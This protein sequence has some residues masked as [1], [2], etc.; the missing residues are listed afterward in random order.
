MEDFITPFQSAPAIWGFEF[1]DSFF[2]PSEISDN[3][4]RFESLGSDV[5]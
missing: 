4:D 5:F 3:G 1:I 2:M